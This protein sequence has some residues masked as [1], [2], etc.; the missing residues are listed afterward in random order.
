M[1]ATCLSA[2]AP[3]AAAV[4]CGRPRATRALIRPARLLGAPRRAAA[5]PRAQAADAPPAPKPAAAKE[6]NHVPLVLDELASKKKI[7]IAQTAP[8]VR[9][10]IG[11]ELGLGVGVNATGK[12]V[13]AL[14]RLGFDYVFDTLAGADLTIMEEG[15]ELLER[16]EGLVNKRPDTAPLPMFTSCCP[17]WIGFVETCAPEIIPHVSSC[18]SPHMMVGSVLKTYFAEKIGK[19]SNE[20]SVVSV[21]PCVRKQGEADRMM[22]HTP[23]GAA[24]EVDHVITTKDLAAMCKE[25]GIDFASL[26]DEEFDE[27]LGIGTGAAALFGTTGGVMEAALRTVYD[28]ATGEKL[29]RL[30]WEPVRGLDGTKEASVVI[31]P[32]PEGPLHNKEAVTVNIA[33]ANGLG[34]AKKLLKQVQEGEK[35]YHF[36]EV[37]ACPGGCIGGGG[38]PR[39]KDKEILQKRQGALYN[40]DERKVLRRSHE[41][42]V[43]QQLYDDFLEKPNSHKAH[44]LLH[45]YYVP[46]GPEKYDITAPVE[47]Q[48]PPLATC[49]LDIGFE[50]VC[51][52]VEHH[53]ICELDDG[54]V[55]SDDNDKTLPTEL[56]A[57]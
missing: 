41:N 56:H 36:I 3:A 57:E 51:D 4:C 42:P 34:N 39:S 35:D 21:M 27:F 12:M 15:F 45:T 2:A 47:E 29:D 26:P 33:V 9:I 14:R 25:K 49:T 16:L 1:Q 28:V 8:A 6:V 18:K 24:R 40:V 31:K 54:T 44:E 48:P 22:F 43:V 50:T 11:E 32:H 30:D 5:A 53:E 23:D 52:P 55:H 7:C 20:I 19:R 38:Q 10:A 37:M 46:C 13:A 17:G